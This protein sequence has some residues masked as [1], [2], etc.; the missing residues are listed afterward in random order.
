[1]LVRNED[2]VVLRGAGRGGGRSS[3]WFPRPCNVLVLKGLGDLVLA[4]RAPRS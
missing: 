1:M 4:G 3:S 2:L